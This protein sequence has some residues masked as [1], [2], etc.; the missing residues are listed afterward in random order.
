MHRRVTGAALALLLALGVPAGAAR[1]AGASQVAQ[2]VT[3]PA[4]PYH[5]GPLP[6]PKITSEQAEA[7]LRE[8]FTLPQ[9]SDTLDLQW[10][11]SSQ[12]D[13]R[14]WELGVTIREEN[15]SMGSNLA[16]V[17]AVTGRVLRYSAYELPPGPL[18]TGPLAPVHSEAEARARAWSLVQKLVPE[19]AAVLK[20]APVGVSDYIHMYYG[21]GLRYGFAAAGEAYRFTWA[22]HH[23]GVAFPASRVSVSVNSQTLEYL[24]VD[25]GLLESIKFPAGPAK[26]TEQGALKLWA[27]AQ[28][29]L[30]YQPIYSAVPFGRPRV[31]GFKLVYGFPNLLRPVDAMTGTWAKNTS[32]YPQPDPETKPAEPEAVPAGNV[33]PVAPPALPLGDAAAQKL[34]RSILELPEG[35]E[36]RSE[37]RFW[38]D[39][40][41][42]G[43]DYWDRTT[44]GSVHFEPN[45]GLIRAASHRT[46]PGQTEPPKVTPE[47]EA[48]ARQA[49]FAVV[50]TY[51]SQLRDQLRLDPRLEYWETPDNHIRRFRFVRYVNGLPVPTDTV[52]VAIDLSTMKWVD[53]NAN[54]TTGVS[55]PSPAGAITPEKAAEA[56]LADRK[57]LLLYQPVYPPISEEQLHMSGRPEPSEAQLVYELTPPP[58]VQVD[59]LTG[60]FLGLD[61]RPLAGAA[62][63]TKQLKGHWAEAELQFALSRGI[64]P[65]EQLRPDGALTRTQAV[66]L[67]LYRRSSPLITHGGRPSVDL[68]YTDLPDTDPAYGVVRAAWTE[69]WLRPLGDDK[70]FRPDAPVTRAE[71]AV[72]AARA[73][74]LGDVARSALSIQAGYKDLGA[75]TAEQRNAAGLLRGLGLLAPADTFRGADP[76]TQAEGAA[77]TV[78]LYNYLL[79][80]QP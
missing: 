8:F 59:A 62:A 6:E 40:K 14:T 80:R 63:A 23:D 48:Q 49:A 73:L 55:F 33:T 32:P 37:D 41:L 64:I 1:A 78:R 11:L 10:H 30:L 7:A 16:A 47:Q 68:P 22:E 27:E 70:T 20:E 12:G 54:W 4:Q 34:A 44:S 17:D 36:L 50:Q 13:K 79:T 5:P 53:M 60:Q 52:T 71:F 9:K 72:W 75:L 66:A 65:A 18:R 42:I 29:I 77:L 3:L 19:Q 56:V 67:L 15:G 57:P 24:N 21:I 46:G 39:E 74:G 45:T 2:T 43:F 35:A 38:S 26:V 31:T 51:Y 58:V 28:P 76:L 69:G 25:V 61:G